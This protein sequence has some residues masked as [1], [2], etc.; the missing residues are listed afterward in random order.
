MFNTNANEMTAVEKDEHRKM[1][2][3]ERAKRFYAKNKEKVLEKGRLTYAINHGVDKLV[4]DDNELITELKKIIKEHTN[5][6]LATGDNIIN[7]S[8]VWC[9]VLKI[10]TITAFKNKIITNPYEVIDRIDTASY[11]NENKDYSNNSKRN[12]LAHLF[13]ICDALEIKLPKKAMTAYQHK[14]DEYNL[15]D[16]KRVIKRNDIEK[17]TLITFDEYIDRVKQVYPEN[18][19][20]ILLVLL[21]SELTCRDDYGRL[22]IIDDTKKATGNKNYIFVGKRDVKIILNQF[23][24][25]KVYKKIQCKL[26]YELSNKV[27]SYITDNKMNINDELFPYDNMSHIVCDINK[28]IGVEGGINTL[29][30]IAVKT[31]LTSDKTTAESQQKLADTMGHSLNIQQ[32]YY[33]NLKI[34]EQK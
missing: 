19:L 14:I 29:R 10:N 2:Q 27:K 15:D 18:S 20:Q 3:R 12:Y 9:K 26:S 25:D 23:K 7:A 13:N 22:I 32:T 6:K 28:K 8:K 1:L 21:Y 16:L 34:E 4:E 30:R 24:T 31:E 11:G 17:E 5:I 33:S